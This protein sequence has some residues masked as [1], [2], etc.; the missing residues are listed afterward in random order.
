MN[1]LVI[2]NQTLGGDALRS[3]LRDISGGNTWVHLVV[4]ATPPD[5]L[6]NEDEFRAAEEGRKR[7]KH[8]LRQGLDMM[9]EQGMQATGEIGNPDPME[10]IADALAANTY[11]EVIVSTLPGGVSRWIKMDLP[12]KASRKFDIHVTHIEAK[13]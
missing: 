5:D 4:P 12:S 8:R 10:A 3:K 7:A 2:A 11:D 6:G 13:A 1:Y 9:S